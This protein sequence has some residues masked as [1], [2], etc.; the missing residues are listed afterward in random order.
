MNK[1]LLVSGFLLLIALVAT[2]I[3]FMLVSTEISSEVQTVN[4]LDIIGPPSSVD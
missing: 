2:V 3:V 1:F 4:S